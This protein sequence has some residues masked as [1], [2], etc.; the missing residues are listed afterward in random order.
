[1]NDMIILSKDA[2]G[3]M[4]SAFFDIACFPGLSE[5][6]RFDKKLVPVHVIYDKKTQK[7]ARSHT[8][9]NVY[10]GKD[11]IKAVLQGGMAKRFIPVDIRLASNLCIT[12]DQKQDL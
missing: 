3:S 8:K 2:G 7:F 10:D 11:L 12:S 5:T 4:I 9:L 1:M 6:F